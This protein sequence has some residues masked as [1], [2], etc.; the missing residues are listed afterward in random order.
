MAIRL[1]ILHGDGAPTKD[2]LLSYELGWSINNKSLYIGS[3]DGNAPIQLTYGVGALPIENGGTGATSAAGIIENLKLIPETGGTFT[4][5]LTLKSNTKLISPNRYYHLYFQDKNDKPNCAIISDKNDETGISSLRFRQWIN[6]TGTNQVSGNYEDFFLPSTRPQDAPENKSYSILTTKNLVGIEQGGTGANNAAD[7][8]AN[9]E[10]AHSLVSKNNY[11][12]LVHNDGSEAN[13]IRTTVNGLIPY[14]S[15]ANGKSYVGTSDWPFIAMH[16]KT[17]Y[18]NVTGN[19]TGD[20]TGNITGKHYLTT[21]GGTWDNAKNTAMIKPSYTWSSDSQYIPIFSCPTKLG[22]WSVGTLQ[23]G[24]DSYEN[25]Y[26]VYADANST[27]N[28]NYK[29]YFINADG[30]FSGTIDW[31]NVNHT[32][33]NNN[34]NILPITNGG[35]GASNPSGARANLGLDKLVTYVTKEVNTGKTWIDNK[36][37]YRCIKTLTGI[38]A[39]NN[40][41]TTVNLDSSPDTL[42]DLRVYVKSGGTNNEGWRPIP[43][44][45]YGDNNWACNVYLKGSL[46]TI[47]FGSK[48]STTDSRTILVIAEYTK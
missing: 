10:V 12:G 16:A 18:G 44:S 29:R 46:V 23:D 17:F 37:I 36:P 15:D 5:G 14:S 39:S 38:T 43:N 30:E 27:N 28:S 8:R 42:V 26:F 9:L 11:F 41:S 3:S 48:W 13:Y 25:L 20:V 40:Q 19:V 21:S 24:S 1:Q 4:G 35:T 45:Y 31:K 33:F 6:T 2:N 22:N 47:G 7:A 32:P 34:N